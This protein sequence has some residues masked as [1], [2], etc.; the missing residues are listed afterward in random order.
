MLD[1]GVVKVP[2]YS[3]YSIWDKKKSC[4]HNCSFILR[5]KAQGATQLAGKSAGKRKIQA[6]KFAVSKLPCH[7]N[8]ATKG[9]NQWKMAKLWLCSKRGRLYKRLIR[10]QMKNNI[11]FF[12]KATRLFFFN[13][14]V[15]LQF[16]CR[17]PWPPKTSVMEQYKTFWRKKNAP[18]MEK[19]TSHPLLRVLSQNF[20][21]PSPSSWPKWPKMDIKS[22]NWMCWCM[23]IFYIVFSQTKYLDYASSTLKAHTLVSK[24]SKDL[25]ILQSWGSSQRIFGDSLGSDQ[26]DNSY[27][28]AQL[29]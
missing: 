5:E 18:T 15:V 8:T 1:W 2:L 25:V 11:E 29:W 7:I 16:N 3:R 27:W 28:V 12:V 6:K 14:F 26:S 23:Y 9:K 13:S 20:Y 22:Y 17:C 21:P 4:K 19:K 24:P 10:V